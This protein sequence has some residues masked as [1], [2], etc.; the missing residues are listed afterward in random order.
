VENGTKMLDQYLSLLV[1]DWEAAMAVE[2]HAWQQT[3][4]NDDYKK[5]CK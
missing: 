2:N 3:K 1:S 4:N 5:I